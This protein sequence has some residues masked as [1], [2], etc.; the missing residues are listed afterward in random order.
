MICV[1]DYSNNHYAYRFFTARGLQP[2][3]K[4]LIIWLGDGPSCSAVADAF[5][6]F[7]PFRLSYTSS[8]WSL[9]Q[10]PYSWVQVSINANIIT[11]EPIKCDQ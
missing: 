6:D 4:P 11:S 7:G 9:D 1:I 2:E 8:G 10:N 3:S 5:E